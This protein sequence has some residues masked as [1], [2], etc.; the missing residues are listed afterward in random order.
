MYAMLVGCEVL[1]D[2]TEIRNRFHVR[3][4]TQLGSNCVHNRWPIVY[5]IG[6]L[7]WTQ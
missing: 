1:G 6:V 2:Q 5:T 7:L 3:M 4:S